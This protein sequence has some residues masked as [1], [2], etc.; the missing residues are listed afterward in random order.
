MFFVPHANIGGRI[1]GNIP[2]LWYEKGRTSD[3]FMVEKMHILLLGY[4]KST[5]FA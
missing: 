2:R 3:K 1:S 4:K 5:I